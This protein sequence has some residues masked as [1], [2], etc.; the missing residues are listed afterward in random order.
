MPE[1]ET[2]MD[3]LDAEA[4]APD[5]HL[6][7][8]T[9]ARLR[10][11]ELT[12]EPREEAEA[13]L[14]GCA[15]C[16]ARVEAMRQDAADFLARRPAAALTGALATRE[17]GPGLWERLRRLLTRP[18]LGLGLAAAVTAG[19]VLTVWP[20]PSE[21]PPDEPKTRLKT[22]VALEFH[23]LSGGA[24]SHGTSGDTL[25]PGDRI[26]LRYST[27]E[28]GWLVVVSL[29]SRGAVTPF[30]DSDGRSLAIEP[31]VA[32][33]LDGSIE[34]DDALGPERL[35]GCFSRKP[36]ST[37]RVVA[38]G[39]RALAAAGGDPA[40]VSALDVPCAQ[41]TVIIRKTSTLE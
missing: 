40:A 4:P 34:L 41:A 1:E 28:H 37:A 33:L 16:E 10:A 18:A 22:A 30:Y 39:Q 36:L 17:R 6:G 32:H 14:A 7:R 3:W 29:D 21:G 31:G 27:P 9:L 38:A 8:H 15:R 26:Q 12:G 24:V 2:T 23:V 19:L 11:G 35:L 5:G 20:G 13:H 25:H